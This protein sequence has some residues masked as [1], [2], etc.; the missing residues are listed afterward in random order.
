MSRRI[1]I[2]LASILL[3]GSAAWIF[4][5][6][7]KEAARHADSITALTLPSGLEANFHEMLW[8]TPGEGLVYRFRFVAPDFKETGDVD[9]VMA[10]LQYLC[11]EY[12]LP[13][14]A[15]NTGPTPGQLI[16]SLADK[17]SEFGTYDPN[18]VQV[19]EAFDIKTGTCIW[20]VF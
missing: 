19:F 18:V 7:E 10:D 5:G 20:E 12:A 17:T 11:A 14:L 8:N 1:L 3:V 2:L 6:A 16:I 13:K 4:F 15:T 9:R